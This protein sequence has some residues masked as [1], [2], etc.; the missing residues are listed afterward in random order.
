MKDIAD[1]RYDLARALTVRLKHSDYYTAWHRNSNRS[2]STNPY[3]ATRTLHCDIR[4]KK[5]TL[6]NTETTYVKRTTNL[7]TSTLPIADH[8]QPSLTAGGD[9]TQYRPLPRH[10]L[11]RSRR[12]P[13]PPRD[14]PPRD[15][16]PRLPVV[17][18][19]HGTVIGRVHGVGP[20]RARRTVSRGTLPT[21]RCAVQ[22][23]RYTGQ[24]PG[25]RYSSTVRYWSAER[26]VCT[27]K[28]Q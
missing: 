9:S 17:I 7:C 12:D 1:G 20:P 3:P 26:R 14:P 10:P 5:N 6:K 2:E 18:A 25:Y 19:V 21:C 22:R 4:R 11:P 24:I 13:P 8:P 27:A 15:P 23:Y 16:R 28:R